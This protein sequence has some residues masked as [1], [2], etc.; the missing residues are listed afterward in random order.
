MP[1]TKPNDETTGSRFM[2]AVK[3][4]I[5]I[6][7]GFKP[8][9][10]QIRPLPP[11]ELAE[12]L[13]KLA[14]WTPAAITREVEF[15]SFAETVGFFNSVAAISAALDHYPTMTVEQN[16][17]QIT[18]TTPGVGLTEFDFALAERVDELL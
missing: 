13:Q 8:E 7:N 16:R 18:L 6:L 11:E 9:R 14:H 15:A 17:V 5:D 1:T 12:S 3:T 4:I 2:A 10:I